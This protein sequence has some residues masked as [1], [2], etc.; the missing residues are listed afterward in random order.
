[1]FGGL[2]AKCGVQK[3]LKPAHY[4]EIGDFLYIFPSEPV[5]R[6]MKS[7]CGSKTRSNKSQ[8]FFQPGGREIQGP[9]V[10]KITRN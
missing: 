10:N 3:S 7:V 1:M 5:C 8:W 2:R 4:M 9:T 6:R